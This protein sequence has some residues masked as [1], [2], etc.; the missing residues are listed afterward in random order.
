MTILGMLLSVSPGL[1]FMS[2]VITYKAQWDEFM[3]QFIYYLFPPAI[4]LIGVPSKSNA[5]RSLL[6][7]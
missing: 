2:M 1:I 6:E 7:M 3:A 5:F 4:T